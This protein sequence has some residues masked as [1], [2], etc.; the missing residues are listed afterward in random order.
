MELMEF[1]VMYLFQVFFC[2][3]KLYSFKE[4]KKICSLDI[5]ADSA[6]FRSLY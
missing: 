6:L 4:K 1:V 2:Y 3:P 5:C